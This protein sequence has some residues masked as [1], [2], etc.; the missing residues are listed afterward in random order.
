MSADAWPFL[1][2]RGRLTRYQVVVVPDFLRTPPEWYPLMLL[3]AGQET[4]TD[5]VLVR[6]VARAGRHTF[7][8]AYRMIRPRAADYGLD[9]SGTLHDEAGRPVLAASGLILR[10][11]AHQVSELG[12]TTTDLGR[13]L[14]RTR[15]AYRDVWLSPEPIPPQRSVALTAGGTDGKALLPVARP[16]ITVGGS[17]TAV[18]KTAPRYRVAISRTGAALLVAASA[19]IVVLITRGPQPSSPPLTVATAF[20]AALEETDS[21]AGFNRVSSGTTLSRTH[22]DSVFAVFGHATDC[23]PT[24]LPGT[25]SQRTAVL[26]VT[27]GGTGSASAIRVGLTETAQNTWQVTSAAVPTTASRDRH[28]RFDLDCC[29]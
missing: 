6:E 7:T 28:S 10:M 23:T 4:A 29:G 5:E 2:G 12:L 1:V 8:A 15:E 27:S 14:E 22:F 26:S 3:A 16:V 9:E 13:V 25:G 11:P 17:E 24:V 20:C 18:A 21:T 19:T